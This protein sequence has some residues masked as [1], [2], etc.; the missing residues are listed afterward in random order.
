MA[1]GDRKEPSASEWKVL[2]AVWERPRSTARDV[3]EELEA[4]E[5]WAASTVKTLLRRLVEKGHLT[6]REDGPTMVYQAARGLRR[7]LFQAGEELLGRAREDTVGPLLAHLVK[8][9]DLSS[10]ELA[11]LRSMIEA[12]ERRRAR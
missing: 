12:E 4:R 5:G 11:E 6:T 7:S 2:R 8:R 1:R 9:S 3:C 10:D